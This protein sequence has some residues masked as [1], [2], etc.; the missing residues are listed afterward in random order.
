MENIL[1]IGNGFDIAH[2]FNTRYE[3][4]INFCKT[5]ATDYQGFKDNQ[6]IYQN[7]YNDILKEKLDKVFKEKSVSAKAIKY[8]SNLTPTSETSQFIKACKENYWLTYVLKNKSMIGD[9]WSDLEYVIAKQIEILS[10]ISNNLNWHTREETMLASRYSSNLIELFKIV[11]EERGNNTD[12]QHQIELT[13]KHLY[14]ELEELTWLLEIYLTRFLNTKTKKIELFKYLPVTK[15]ISFNYTD[16]YTRMY[17]KETNT[18]HYIH[19]FAAKDRIKEENNMV[20]GIGSEIKNVTDNDKYDYLEFQ[21]YYQRIVKKTGNNY[22]KWL[23][24]NEQFYIY[25]FGHSLD[26]VDGDVIRKL[27]HCKKAKVIIFY[28]NQK[29][30]NALVVN[31]AKILGKDELIQFTNE[32]KI[33][34]YKSDDLEIIKKLKN[35]MYQT[36]H[37]KLK[38]TV[39]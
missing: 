30:L 24:D 8:F 2:G 31:L 20:F 39:R 18:V 33:T 23:N 28:Y 1:V 13:K 34:F 11:T 15:L 19:G 5:I 6:F 36:R 10:Y 37:E 22:T 27:I 14:R 29:A 26:I 12:F 4:F 9:K 25:F 3:D 32:E 17:K 16:T 7:E 38:S 35:T 21:K